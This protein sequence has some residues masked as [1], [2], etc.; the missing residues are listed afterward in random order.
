MVG[1]TGRGKITAKSNDGAGGATELLLPL[2]ARVSPFMLGLPS[3]PCR[4]LRTAP[5]DS[6]GLELSSRVGCSAHRESI[7]AG[8]SLP[9]CRTTSH[10][11]RRRPPGS[12]GAGR[13]RISTRSR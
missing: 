1:R 12:G 8:S 11:S 10:N 4:C 9:G 2:A 3:R 7:R 5:T 13:S 6:G